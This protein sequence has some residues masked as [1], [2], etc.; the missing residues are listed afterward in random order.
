[1]ILLLVLDFV[2]HLIFSIGS[3]ISS[4]LHNIRNFHRRPNPHRDRI[5]D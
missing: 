4:H 3:P 1:L 2:H 5:R